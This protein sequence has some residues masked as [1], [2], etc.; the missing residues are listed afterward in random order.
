[1]YE[2]LKMLRQNDLFMSIRPDT[3]GGS[4]VFTFR[5][6]N[7]KGTQRNKS[8]RLTDTEVMALKVDIEDVLID[9]GR[10][11]MD[12][13]NSESIDALKGE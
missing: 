3:E 1:M 5:K 11:F 13:F 7:H 9:F 6:T 4:M 12:E 8:Y 2:L 10:R